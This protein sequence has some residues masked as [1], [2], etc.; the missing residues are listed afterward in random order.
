MALG[1][2]GKTNEIAH[3]SLNILMALLVYWSIH[4]FMTPYF[5]CYACIYELY[6]RWYT[7]CPIHAVA[8]SP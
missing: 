2:P 3:V 4:G 6:I 5:T 8:H 1:R 7:W